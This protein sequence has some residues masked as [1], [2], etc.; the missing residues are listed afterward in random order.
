[1]AAIDRGLDAPLQ[2]A[3][4]GLAEIE[5]HGV[6]LGIDRLAERRPDQF[7]VTERA[8]GKRSNRR[9]KRG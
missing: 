8:R 5:T 9:S 3:G 1:M 6:H 2:F 7:A 4:D